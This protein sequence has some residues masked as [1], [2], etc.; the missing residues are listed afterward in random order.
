[1]RGG[2]A[3]R[4]RVAAA[5]RA[6][7][8]GRCRAWPA[9]HAIHVVGGGAGDQSLGP[10]LV[11]LRCLELILIR[12]I[13]AFPRLARLGL[14]RRRLG[15]LEDRIGA[16]ER[17]LHAQVLH[18][19]Q[20]RERRKIV[21]LLQAEVVQE[22]A[23]GAEQLGPPR[24]VAMADDPY[25]AALEQRLDDVRVHRDAANLLDLPARDRL[26]IGHQRQGLEQ[27]A[28]VFGRAL[29]PESGDG[30]R[31]G[32]TDLDAIA[33]RDFDDLDAASLVIGLQGGDRAAD[34]LG[35]R[36]VALVEQRDQLVGLKRTAGGEQGGLNHVA[37]IVVVHW[38]LARSS[39]AAGAVAAS[40]SVTSF[41][42]RAGLPSRTC[43]GP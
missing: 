21:E 28:R 22:L 5:A 43:K 3:A 19:L 35:I 40:S 41:K 17:E 9:R 24:H 33:A 25:P 7:S 1:M 32:R 4:A 37:Y 18:L 23:G 38:L 14:R 26:A 15:R 11:G 12:R 27:G 20:L 31:D 39:L 29:L 6:P 8:I 10:R 2:R 42:C 34:L 13:A 30:L 16:R 36:S